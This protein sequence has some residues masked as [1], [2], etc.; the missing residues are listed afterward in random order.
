MNPRQERYASWLDR[1]QEL[2]INSTGDARWRPFT[3]VVLE[4]VE[5][6]VRW[7]FATQT[8]A[9]YEDPVEEIFVLERD[10]GGGNLEQMII[11]KNDHD[12]PKFKALRRAFCE[13]SSDNDVVE[14]P[15]SGLSHSLL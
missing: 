6:R 7:G 10:R 2:A 3:E 14:G 1:L 9:L 13:L 11:P 15:S 4:G 12:W 8:F 5:M